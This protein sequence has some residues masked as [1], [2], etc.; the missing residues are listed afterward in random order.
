MILNLTYPKADNARKRARESKAKEKARESG[1]YPQAKRR[2]EGSSKWA[3]DFRY[4]ARYN[5]K[6]TMVDYKAIMAEFAKRS[7]G[8]AWAMVRSGE[9]LAESETALGTGMWVEY[10]DRS[11]DLS[12]LPPHK[13]LGHSK[14]NIRSLI[15]QILKYYLPVFFG[16][17]EGADASKERHEK[18]VREAVDALGIK[19]VT[20]EEK[21]PRAKWSTSVNAALW[22]G[23]GSTSAERN[24]KFLGIMAG[25][26]G[27]TYPHEGTSVVAAFPNPDN[28][29]FTRLIIK[30]SPVR[31]L[32]HEPEGAL[33][34]MGSSL[35][36][37][38]SATSSTPRRS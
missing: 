12:Q 36:Q 2:K 13:R 31:K 16:F 35:V 29:L 1:V 20:L 28:P 11:T 8:A 37:G 38:I 9:T 3:S 7:I 4:P 24:E 19:P 30:V 21:D 32:H 5:D 23:C 27:H 34:Q 17:A 6:V 22:E 33:R 14:S 25:L 15:N 10:G 26:K 18:L